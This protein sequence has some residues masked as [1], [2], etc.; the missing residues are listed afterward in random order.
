MKK[1]LHNDITANKIKLEV[2]SLGRPRHSCE[3]NIKM[4][5][6]NGVWGCGLDP[7]DSGK[8][9]VAGSCEHSNEISGFVNA[10]IFLTT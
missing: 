9:P 4:H 2:R 7:S 1:K 5:L 6:R 10:R 8:G 3:D